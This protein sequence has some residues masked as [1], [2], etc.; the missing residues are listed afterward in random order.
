MNTYNIDM[1]IHTTDSDGFLKDYEICELALKAGIK[2]L[3]ITDH[4]FSKDLS[5]L[6]QAYSSLKIIQGSEISCIYTTPSLKEVEIHVIALGFCLDSPKIQNIFHRNRQFD[7]KPYINA[8]LDKLHLCGINLCYDD[9]YRCADGQNHIGRMHI[10]TALKNNGFVSTIDEAFDKYI[11]SF[12][13][14]RAYVPNPFRYVKLE[15]AISAI[16]DSSGIP[17]LAHLNYYEQLNTYEKEELVKYFKQLAG[18]HAGIEV[19]YSR[20]TEYER[21]K[22]KDLADKYNLMYSAASDFHGIPTDTLNNSFSNSLCP[23]LVKIL[24]TK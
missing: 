14:K 23:D 11:G 2:M 20:Y 8:I 13:E 3:A 6:R 5:V 7:R 22:I 18:K 12:G 21:K 24:N 4:N 9:V 17:V 1:H 15:E 16:I 10:A 19:Y